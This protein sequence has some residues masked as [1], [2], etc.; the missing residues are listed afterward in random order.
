VIS[1]IK[2]RK[3][4]EMILEKTE[5]MKMYMN[6]A[7]QEARKG[8]REGRGGPFGAVV[9]KEG[10]VISLASNEVLSSHDPTAHA[11]MVAIRRA[12]EKLQSY[13]L[14]GCVLFATGEPCPMCFSAIV[15]ANIKEVYYAASIEDAEVIGF[16]DCRIYR[17]LHGEECILEMKRM[18]SAEVLQLYEEYKNLKKTIY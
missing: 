6:L 17:H 16:R 18:E 1:I 5:D 4:P 14:S 15:W 9:V 7:A 12:S 10:E 3:G 13:D 11:E 8:I 2:E